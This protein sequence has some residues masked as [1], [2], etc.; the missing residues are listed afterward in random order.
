MNLLWDE[1]FLDTDNVLKWCSNPKVAVPVPVNTTGVDISRQ[2]FLLVSL[3][4]NA[5]NL[6][7][8]PLNL[9]LETQALC[10][11]PDLLFEQNNC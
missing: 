8:V 7:A 5:S 2:P 4:G 9:N 11:I 10:Q 3:A 1:A 6:N